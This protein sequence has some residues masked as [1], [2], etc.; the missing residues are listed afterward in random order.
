M[1]GKCFQ[2]KDL[3]SLKCRQPEGDGDGGIVSK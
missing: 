1:K 2:I 3:S